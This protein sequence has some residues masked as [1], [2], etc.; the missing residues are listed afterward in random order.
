VRAVGGVEVGILWK[1]FY[2]GQKS[3]S[4]LEIVTM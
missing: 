4:G 3:M 2:Q 1:F